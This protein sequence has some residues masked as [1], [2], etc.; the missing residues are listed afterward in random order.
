M[1]GE[2]RLEAQAARINLGEGIGRAGA[3]GMHGKSN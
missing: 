1:E 2:S 3:V